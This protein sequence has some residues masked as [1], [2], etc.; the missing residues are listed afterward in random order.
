M[1]DQA[2]S[3]DSLIGLEFSHYR[4][5]KKIGSGGMGVV[6]LARD[7]H[8]D[9]DVALKLLHP[10]TI[11]DETVR[12]RFHNEA[13]ALSKLNHPNIATIH[14]FDTQGGTNFLVME[15]IPGSPLSTRLAAGPLS[16]SEVLA[17][18]LQLVEGLTAAH[19]H[20]IIH[21]DLKPANLLITSDRRLKILDFGLAKLRL[22]ITES[23][24]Q[25]LLESRS[26]AG[27]F[28]YM[29]PEQLLGGDLDGRTDLYA[30]GLIL[31]EMATGQRPFAELPSSKLLD[32]ILHRPP[33]PPRQLNSKLSFE[34][35]NIISKCLEKNPFDRYQSAKEL[36]VDLR[37]LQRDSSADTIDFSPLA[38][39]PPHPFLRS[40]SFL[41]FLAAFLLLSS[42]VTALFLL[43]YRGLLP[44]FIFGAPRIQSIAV[45]PL[46]NLSGDPD[47]EFFADGV[48]EE[49]ITQ[50]GKS[51]NLRVISRQ[52]VMQ[53]KH[54]SLP[55]SEIARKLDVD[56]V[57]EG[58]VLQS[59]NR[60]R[61]TARLVPAFTERP[62]WTEQYD[63]DLRDILTLQA[64][65]TQA[66]AGEIKLKLSPEE[67]ARLTSSRPVN[68]EAFEAYLKGRFYWYQVSKSGFEEAERYFHMALEKDPQ[69]ALAYSGLSDVWLMRTDTG[70]LAP[71][72]VYDKAKAYASRA[73]D[74][75]P[76]LAEPHVSLGN[77]AAG[78]DRDWPAAERH[79]LRA[80]EVNPSSADAHFMYADL[81]ISLKRNQEW[82]TEIHRCLTLDP[83][84]YFYRAFYA[85]HLIYL[86]RYDEAIENLRN[87]LTS[88]PGFS[89]AHMGLW[90]AYFKKHMD[91]EA[92]SEAVRFFEI[93][94][95][96]EAVDA[97]RAGFASAGY[98]EA[99]KR[100]G[101]VLAA[102]S[103][104]THV[105]GIRIARLYAHAGQN[106]LALT[107][108]ERA[109]DAHETPVEHLAVAWDWEAL[110]PDPRFQALLLQLNLP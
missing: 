2:L 3:L 28:P 80:I 30:T 81:L 25:S 26:I 74:L 84:D 83:M 31:Y 1:P 93:L 53:F 10:G 47:R 88:S 61:V 63:R 7:S 17:L 75:D 5:L 60:V 104:H 106:E 33:I 16:E 9:R 46:A 37:R 18:A 90:G 52:S 41:A 36:A 86:G 29:A 54:T 58:S 24:T 6:Y 50:L 77:I 68:P 79:F 12:H 66:I 109:V 21:R 51:T 13:L 8:L 100:A 22:P 72:E 67:K 73:L 102:R 34:L 94:N 20:S 92:Y 38:P 40:K 108:L 27:T 65:V 82:D 91:R 89:S 103:R 107:W 76:T 71:F 55:V 14:D 85:W 43:R 95:D 44:T 97:L 64:D 56:A 35:E 19:E 49:L 57:V 42:L 99:M 4:I 48:T 62:L 98:P 45:L 70:Y 69:Y 105:P 23:V 32:A 39:A 78:Y 11:S 110:R 101:D 59:G 87:V 96:R 15:Y